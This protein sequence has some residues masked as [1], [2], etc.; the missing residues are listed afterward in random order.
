MHELF[1][2]TGDKKVKQ[3]GKNNQNA[4]MCG[5][6]SYTKTCDILDVGMH[7]YMYT[8]ARMYMCVSKGWVFT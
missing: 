7:T 8:Y 1:K 2:T 6:I 5:G 4:K 3:Q